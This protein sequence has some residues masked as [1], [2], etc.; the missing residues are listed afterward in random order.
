MAASPA[1]R[2]S[3]LTDYLVYWSKQWYLI[4]ERTVAAT[5]AAAATAA[6]AAAAAAADA[7]ADA[8]AA[9]VVRAKYGTDR[10]RYWSLLYGVCD[11]RAALGMGMEVG[12]G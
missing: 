9:D 4:C 7:P 11:S 3:T 6:A 5:M 1:N 12:E 2:Q 8:A 10:R